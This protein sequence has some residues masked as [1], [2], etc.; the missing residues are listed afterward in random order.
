MILV[1]PTE[2]PAI[3]RLGRTSSTPE[4]HGV[5][6]FWVAKGNKWGIQRKQF[7]DDFMA[8]LNDGRLQKEIIQMK[9]LDHAVLILEG[10]GEWTT[11]GA[12]VSQ[13]S[14]E[15]NQFFGMLWSLTLE[16]G[17]TTLRVRGEEELVRAVKSLEAWSKKDKHLSLIRRPKPTSPWGVV[18]SRDW[19]IHLL[20]SF[21]GVGAG[22]AGAMY[23]EFGGVPLRWTVEDPKGLEVVRGIGGVTAQRLWD[24]LEEESP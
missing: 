3:R 4:K 10:Y 7:P 1:S 18:S 13:W 21:E 8:S 15:S 6:L 17:I 19:G 2:P 20:Q 9:E 5:D 16:H 23:D 12:L 11:E 22:L 14:M 24:A